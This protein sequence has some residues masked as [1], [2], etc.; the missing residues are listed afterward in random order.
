MTA[1]MGA[2]SAGKTTCLDVL[3]QRKG[4]GVVSGDLLISGRPLGSDFTRGTA[5]A[6]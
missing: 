2:S 4:I 6:E 3:V 5:R 1:P